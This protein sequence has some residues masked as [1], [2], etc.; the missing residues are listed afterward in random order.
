VYSLETETGTVVVA[1]GL[2]CHNC[3]PKDVR[4]L[5]AMGRNTQQPLLMMDAVDEINEA[6]K[7]V[8]WHKV[9][10]HYGDA[11]PTKTLAIWGLAFKPR[12]DDIREAPALVLIDRLLAVGAQV[13]VH[14]PEAMPNVRA[15]YGD[16]ITYCDR[17]YGTLEGAD[18]LVLVTEWQEFRRPDFG[19]VK[20]LLREP[21]L[22]DGR[23]IYDPKNLARL[24][25]RYYGI[26]R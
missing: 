11:L 14:D 20:K 5:Q 6:Q 17:P 2:V 10:K 23:N 15:I 12:T 26:G 1:S 8:L 18:G 3:F 22:F 24:G 7:L 25:F 21:V 9:R 4:A 19:V 16:R 13:R